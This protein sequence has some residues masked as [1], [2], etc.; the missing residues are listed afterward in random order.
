MFDKG[1]RIRPRSYQINVGV[2][3][4]RATQCHQWPV[5]GISFILLKMGDTQNL[6]ATSHMNMPSFR[7]LNYIS[8]TSF[9]FGDE[10]PI[11]VFFIRQI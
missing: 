2:G 1:P 8:L 11:I 10:L 7:K 4:V 5:S 6:L 3:N 9:L